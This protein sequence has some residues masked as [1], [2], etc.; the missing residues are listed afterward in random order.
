MFF[1]QSLI[2]I[3]NAILSSKRAQLCKLVKLQLALSTF[4]NYV[5]LL[6]RAEEVYALDISLIKLLFL[7]D[8]NVQNN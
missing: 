3:D 6:C 4:S 7:A 1:K 2:I 5:H 8:L